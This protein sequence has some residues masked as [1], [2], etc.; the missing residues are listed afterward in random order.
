[1]YV[2]AHG[3]SEPF[4]S[5]RS[6]DHCSSH[7]LVVCLVSK[8]IMG[9]RASSLTYSLEKRRSSCQ[10]T[11]PSLPRRC[12]LDL[13]DPTYTSGRRSAPSALRTSTPVAASLPAPAVR[14]AG[15]SEHSAS[16]RNCTRTQRCPMPRPA[17]TLQWTIGTHESMPL[18]E[19]QQ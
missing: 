13:L 17:A 5:E 4:L 14:R 6:I 11:L 1:M 3:R 10:Q 15:L 19:L 18:R 8:D 9:R 16:R 7:F 12:G 2:V